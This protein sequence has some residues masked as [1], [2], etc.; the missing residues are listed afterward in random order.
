MTWGA[1][2]AGGCDVPYLPQDGP[3]RE[4]RLG[5]RYTDLLTVMLSH[6]Q[7]SYV[8]VCVCV[9]VCDVHVYIHVWCTECLLR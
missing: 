1:H 7:A 9:C 5:K 3:E 4:K 6:V 8:R 2:Y